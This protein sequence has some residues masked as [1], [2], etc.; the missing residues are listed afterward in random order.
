M[1]A[2]KLS[3]A[4]ARTLLAF[5]TQAFL[6]SAGNAKN[7]VTYRRGERIFTQGE[8]CEHVL[9]IR[10]GGVKLSVLSK[11]GKEAV[12]AVLGPGDF[13]GEGGLAGQPCRIGSATAITPR[14]IVLVSKTKMAPLLHHQHAK[15]GRFIARLLARNNR[16]EEDLI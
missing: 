6:D 14:V 4:A 3:H 12:V 1:D 15:S 9:Y 7:S 2:R 5:D 11:T 8:R 10:K 16:I 13:F